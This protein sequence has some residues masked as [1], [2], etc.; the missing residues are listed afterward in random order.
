MEHI[1]KNVKVSKMFVEELKSFKS[2]LVHMQAIFKW[3]VIYFWE[4]CETALHV[5]TPAVI[6]PAAF[7]SLLLVGKIEGAR[8]EMVLVPHLKPL[9]N[10]LKLFFA[11]DDDFVFEKLIEGRVFILPQGKS[12]IDPFLQCVGMLGEAI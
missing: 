9:K 6:L 7:D 5:Q 10:V 1:L 4:G 2:H 8:E 12:P 3:N 11:I